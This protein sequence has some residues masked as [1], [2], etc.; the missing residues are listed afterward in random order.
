[1]IEADLAA[2]R[3]D[4]P[5]EAVFSNAV[6]HWVPD[7]AA[8]FAALFAA[9]RPGGRL[10][11]QCGGEG[12]VQRFHEAVREVGER[13]PFREFLAGWEGPW[14][15]AGA[16]ETAARLRAAG[17]ERI[18][19]SLAPWP[20][21]PEEPSEYL[22]TVC[23]GYHLKRLPEEL[24]DRYAEAVAEACGQPLWLDYVRL[25]ISAARPAV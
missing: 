13:E 4:E 22:R 3:L 7:H 17:F 6:F 9:L 1:M 21:A 19:T 16:E 2:L 14:N 25:N 15:F 10:E 5:V 24:R 12:N 23:L 20:V 8:L 18:E 11:A